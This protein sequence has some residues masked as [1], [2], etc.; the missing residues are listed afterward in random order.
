MRKLLKCMPHAQAHVEE[1]N[2][3]YELYS[4]NTCVATLTKDDWF[5]IHHWHISPTTRRH[6]T[7][8]M[9][10]YAHGC[11]NRH[12]QSLAHTESYQTCK[13]LFEGNMKMNIKTGEVKENEG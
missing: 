9:D 2:N 7:A 11:Q 3:H 12:E 1:Y 8:F 13:A 6:I 10:E 5:T 4:Y